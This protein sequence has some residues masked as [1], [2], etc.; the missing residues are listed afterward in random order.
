MYF[1]ATTISQ[2]ALLC[3]F[4]FM[5]CAGSEKQNVFLC[6]MQPAHFKTVH[7]SRP[8]HFALY[9]IYRNYRPNSPFFLFF[10]LS[11]YLSIQ[12]SIH[13]SILSD[14]CDLGELILLY[15][16]LIQSIHQIVISQYNTL[17]LGIWLAYVGSGL[18]PDRVSYMKL[19]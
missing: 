3:S 2:L 4:H 11:S 7:V 5:V 12:P 16:N 6:A 13:P 10:Y 8:G 17:S 19:S 9:I 14:Q 15:S 1:L 18:G